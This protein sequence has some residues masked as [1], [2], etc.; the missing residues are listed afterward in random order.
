VNGIDQHHANDLIA[1]Q[2]GERPVHISAERV[3]NENVWPGHT[4]CIQQYM[5]L[6]RNLLC[7]ARLARRI[8]PAVPGAV[9]AHRAREP[10][11]P[12]LHQRPAQAGRAHARFED[13]SRCAFSGYEDVHPP[14]VE[15][16]EVPRRRKAPAIPPRSSDL[17]D[18]ASRQQQN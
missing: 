2:V 9:I 5:Q 1:I 8:A 15:S 18:G 7:G 4:C 13:H 6:L 11:H 14:L 16:H 3:P 17:V 10:C 12:W